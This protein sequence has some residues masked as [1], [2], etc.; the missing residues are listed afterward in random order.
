MK[1]INDLEELAKC[2]EKKFELHRRFDKME[3]I[4]TKTDFDLCL[5][6]FQVIKDKFREFEQ[7]LIPM[8]QFNQNEY[9]AIP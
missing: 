1:N 2:L 6:K 7:N 9:Q 5:E 4:L 8:I 3:S